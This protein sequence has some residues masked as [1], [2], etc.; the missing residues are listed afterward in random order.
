MLLLGILFQGKCIG[1]HDLEKWWGGK[2]AKFCPGVWLSNSRMASPRLRVRGDESKWDVWG[3][4]S[5]LREGT[6]SPEHA[7]TQS[8]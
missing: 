5:I 8:C 2:F 1:Y 4:Q 6:L 7:R 3:L